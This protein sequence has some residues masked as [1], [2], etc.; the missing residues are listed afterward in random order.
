[1]AQVDKLIATYSPIPLDDGIGNLAYD[2]LKVHAKSHG[3][4]VFDSL[5]AA[6]ALVRGLVL[7][8]RNRKHFHMISNLLLE[9]PDY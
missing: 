7:V 9:I 3:L 2:L 6:T 4:R 1:V 5:I 8:T